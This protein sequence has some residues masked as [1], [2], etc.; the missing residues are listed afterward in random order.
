MKRVFFCRRWSVM[1]SRWVS[2]RISDTSNLPFSCHER[3]MTKTSERAKKTFY[4]LCLQKKLNVRKLIR[5]G[6]HRKINDIPITSLL[7]V[8][9]KKLQVCLARERWKII[10]KKHG[11]EQDQEIWEIIAIKLTF[12]PIRWQ[13]P[14]LRRVSC[15]L[16]FLFL[17]FHLL[18]SI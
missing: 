14:P 10:F 15:K 3:E 16:T 11:A 7:R 8:P 2:L 9:W 4:D 5:I 12:I 13:E 17:F 18:K 6:I 1:M